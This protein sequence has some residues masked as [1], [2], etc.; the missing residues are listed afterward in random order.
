MHGYRLFEQSFLVAQIRVVLD[1]VQLVNQL[2]KTCFSKSPCLQ[3]LACSGSDSSLR[4]GLPLEFCVCN[5]LPVSS[6]VIHSALEQIT[7]SRYAKSQPET[8]IEHLVG[9]Q[10]QPRG[11]QVHA[12]HLSDQ[13]GH[14]DPSFSRPHLRG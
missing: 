2:I 6:G 12:V 10:D 3:I 4:S 8:V 9:K 14:Q 1:T 13:K 5:C 11:A 7:C